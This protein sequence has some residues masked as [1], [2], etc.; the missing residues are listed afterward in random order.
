[1]GGGGDECVF[2]VMLPSD[3]PFPGY[4]LVRTMPTQCLSPYTLN[5]PL[6]WRPRD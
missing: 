6:G 2:D 4:K 1:M 3:Y 5:N